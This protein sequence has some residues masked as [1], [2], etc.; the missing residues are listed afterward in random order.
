M[1]FAT[2]KVAIILWKLVVTVVFLCG[3]MV[4]K[5]YVAGGTDKTN[6][7]DDSQRSPPALGVLPNQP[8]C[9]LRPVVD[10]YPQQKTR[11]RWNRFVSSLP[12][13]VVIRG[14]T[15]AY[16]PWCSSETVSFLRPRARRA[17]KTRRP[18]LVDILSRKPCLFTL[19]RL[20]GWNVLFIALS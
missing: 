19:L 7:N 8:F 2:A 14:E 17:A 20:W 6:Q 13:N 12:C 16:L 18:F 11:Q 5:F 15:V 3:E 9:L 10:V 4:D 1:A